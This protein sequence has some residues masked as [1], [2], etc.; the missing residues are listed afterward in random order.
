MN[1]AL[2]GQILNLEYLALGLWGQIFNLEYLALHVGR[3]IVAI[4]VNYNY[5][6]IYEHN[7]EPLA[8]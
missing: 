3:L 7:S 4:P 5:K 2:W 6:A 8:G 1:L